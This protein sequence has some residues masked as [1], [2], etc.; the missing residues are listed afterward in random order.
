M[1]KIIFIKSLICYD[2][3]SNLLV[4]S[5]LFMAQNEMPSPEDLAKTMR[6]Q[7]GAFNFS[8]E[9]KPPFLK[10]PEEVM[11]QLET[12]E[13]VG[14]YIKN[15]KLIEITPD[16]PEW[17]LYEQ[18]RGRPSPDQGDYLLRQTEVVNIENGQRLS[19]EHQIYYIGK[20]GRVLSTI[21]SSEIRAY[22]DFLKNKGSGRIKAYGDRL[23]SDLK[24]LGF[25][26][27]DIDKRD[28]DLI[29]GLMEAK[30]RRLEQATKEQK[31]K[32]FD[33]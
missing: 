16:D 33:F 1:T 21:K 4:N 5:I 12:V 32:E 30:K 25:N 31:K 20:K 14:T 7:G 10:L 6:E 13:D 9:E 2:L 26:N 17:K 11:A 28:L 29:V 8:D 3:N 23:E 22:E 19:V 27:N 24:E 15:H 18:R